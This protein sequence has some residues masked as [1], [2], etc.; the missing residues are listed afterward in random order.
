[1]SDDSDASKKL[2]LEIIG[3]GAA[4]PVGMTAATT[5]AAVRAGVAMFREHP[6][7]FVDRSREQAIVAACSWLDK[8][9]PLTDRLVALAT[10]A[11]GEAR[12]KAPEAP[13]F[14]GL[15]EP[16]PG[17]SQEQLAEVCSRLTNDLGGNIQTFPSGHAAG[18][19]AL[20]AARAALA[21]GEAEACLVGGV[22]SYL[23]WR[24]ILWLD[25]NDQLHSHS[26]SW[27]FIPG[28]AAGFV[29]VKQAEQGGEANSFT[30]ILGLGLTKEEN[31]IKTETVCTGEAL[32][33]AMREAVAHVDGNGPVVDHL[34]GDLNGE[35]YRADEFGFAL[36]RL[37]ERMVEG[38]E[39]ATPAGCW[40]DVGAASA[41]LFLMLAAIAAEKGYAP[42]G[43]TLCWA[44]SEGGLRGAVLLKSKTK[45]GR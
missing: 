22:D 37:R 24:T 1:M 32:G 8:R 5:A 28:E 20:E 38:I 7:L 27:G 29:V 44:G 10:Q 17:L 36:M 26:Y 13:V 45:E 23:D 3:Y 11:A 15:P 6:A 12:A 14:L 18:F 4:T 9:L 40:G 33:Q 2:D 39:F 41:P 34:I 42:G 25:K 31:R 21:K 19:Q 35:P 16:R 43:R 30:K